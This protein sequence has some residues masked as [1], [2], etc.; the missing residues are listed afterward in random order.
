LPD[1]YAVELACINQ[2][3][4]IEPKGAGATNFVDAKALATLLAIGDPGNVQ[5]PVTY[6]VSAAAGQ[7]PGDEDEGFVWFV[8]N[9]NAHSQN[10]P[11]YSRVEMLGNISPGGQDPLPV[12]HD[13]H[14]MLSLPIDC[15][16]KGDEELSDMI[17]RSIRQQWD[18]SVQ[19]ELPPYLRVSIL[20]DNRSSCVALIDVSPPSKAQTL[21]DLASMKPIRKR[22]PEEQAEFK[23]QQQSRQHR[24]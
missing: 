16:E 15:G 17:K 22:T 13:H 1:R 2:A 18:K 12:L 10:N 8:E 14:G 19:G 4:K 23:A 3:R 6:P 21:L 5:Y 7:E 24:R 11:Q 20:R 9:S